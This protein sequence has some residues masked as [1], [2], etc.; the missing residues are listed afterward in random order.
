MFIATAGIMNFNAVMS[1]SLWELHLVSLDD[2][3]VSC[4]LFPRLLF[5]FLNGHCSYTVI[6]EGLK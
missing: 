2:S 5:H 4:P 1:R 3:D 6:E